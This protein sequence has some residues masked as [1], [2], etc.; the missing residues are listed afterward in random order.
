MLFSERF[1]PAIA[2]GSITLAFRRWRRPTVRTGGTLQSPVGLLAIESVAR[3]DESAITSA[4]ARRAGFA[5]RDE[6]IRV[7]RYRDD[8]L[9]R[10]EF[11]LAGP[12]P[13]IALRENAGLSPE[14][15][16]GLKKRL[17]RLDAASKDGHWTANILRLIDRQPATRAADLAL[18]LGEPDLAR[19]KTRVR[20]LKNLGLTESLGTGYRLSPR[21]RSLLPRLDPNVP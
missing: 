18:Q 1:W 11:H 5:S 12:D 17:A 7:L 3:I 13:R 15:I 8:Q 20:R 10:I 21:G 16:G 6:L 19:F 14:D 2:D 9:Y 4:D